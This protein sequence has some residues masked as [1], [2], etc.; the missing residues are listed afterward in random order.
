MKTTGRKSQEVY[1]ERSPGASGSGALVRVGYDGTTEE[2]E[3]ESGNAYLPRNA[4]LDPLQVTFPSFTLG[5]T[6]EVDFRLNG[7]VSAEE[8]TTAQINT[9]IVVS[10]DGGVTFYTLTPSDSAVGVTT[11]SGADN[12]I[13]LRSLDSIQIVNPM[14]VVVNGV[15]STIPVTSPP[16]VRVIYQYADD[17]MVVLVNG[18]TDEL[19]LPGAILKCS[20]LLAASVFQGPLGQLA[21]A[22]A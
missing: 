20:E 13:L 8:P 5:D 19:T 2:F 15:P 16:I 10:L 7:S 22:I 11:D 12:V 14:P 17:T 6:L 9:Q 1:P 3:I 18:G 4:A 21:I